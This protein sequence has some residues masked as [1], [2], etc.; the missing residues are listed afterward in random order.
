MLRGLP[1][2]GNEVEDAT[3]SKHTALEKRVI[4]VYVKS[5]ET[6]ERP[7]GDYSIYDE[8]PCQMKHDVMKIL[9][10]DDKRALEIL[11]DVAKE[12]K[13]TVK[14]YDLLT[15]WGRLKAFARGIKTAP[16]VVIGSS[17]IEHMPDREELLKILEHAN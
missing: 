9:R 13:S 2:M 1:L 15:S 6:L 11:H 16:T 14:V 7:T 10:P 4:E 12:K 8:H 3:K 5:E 17:K